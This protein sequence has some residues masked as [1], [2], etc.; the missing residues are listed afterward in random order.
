MRL[1]ET[2]PHRTHTQRLALATLWISAVVA[3]NMTAGWFLPILG[4]QLAAVADV[5]GIEHAVEVE[6]V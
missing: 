2:D 3:A 5:L 1:T 6:D 4:V